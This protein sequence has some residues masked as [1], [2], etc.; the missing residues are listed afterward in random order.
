[1]CLLLSFRCFLFRFS[2]FCLLV[3]WRPVRRKECVL[4]SGV[5][6]LEL[7]LFSAG[8]RV[9]ASLASER[10][11]STAFMLRLLSHRVRNRSS[12]AVRPLVRPI[13]D[14]LSFRRLTTT[15]AGIV[16]DDGTPSGEDD[17]VEVSGHVVA[18]DN[19]SRLVMIQ[20]D[21]TKKSTRQFRPGSL[22][23]MGSGAVGCLAFELAGFNFA[24]LLPEAAVHGELLDD[25]SC[26]KG[27]EVHIS[28][29]Q[30]HFHF[31]RSA[32]AG[33]SVLDCFGQTLL[34]STP[35]DAE[36]A[37]P[38]N[39]EAESEIVQLAFNP[40]PG[41][42][43]RQVIRDNIHTG[44][45]ALDALTPFGR[46][47]SMLVHGEAGTGKSSIAMDVILAQHEFGAGRVKCVYAA[48][49]ADDSKM[50][51]IVSNMLAP[52]GDVA[53]VIASSSDDGD[54]GALFAALSACALGEHHRD[55]GDH[56]MVILD[57][58]SGLQRLWDKGWQMAH[59]HLGRETTPPVEIGQLRSWYMP[60]LQR[61][62]KLNDTK[63]GGGSMSIIAM[64]DT[65]P[66]PADHPEVM[67]EASLLAVDTGSA[68]ARP[69]TK[70][71]IED[72]DLSPL[73]LS[74]LNTLRER[75]VEV[76]L[77]MLRQL[78]IRSQ[79]LRGQRALAAAAK[80]AHPYYNAYQVSDCVIVCPFPEYCALVVAGR[81][82]PNNLSTSPRLENFF[83][84]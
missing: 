12:R 59:A 45:T 29:K 7:V 49:H 47:Q 39:A 81:K 54:E 9:S 4:V 79:K 30:L 40:A 52:V 13:R 21:F 32:A 77:R 65:P 28:S 31:D 19:A 76:D 58:V 34:S 73:D 3:F 56:A 11:C 78:G 60:L 25:P 20:P 62:A 16:E 50:S 61:A 6:G 2:F 67:P 70:Q 72:L 46:G 8:R 55:R 64:V 51:S 35:S 24:I 23:Q 48:T 33:G 80:A 43:D 38:T 5:I 22:V 68:D 10:V 71:D 75:G 44:V 42:F 63:K 17:A 83:I 74:R 14:A 36:T 1:M 84:S 37:S 15:S 18:A 57:E 66:S 41:Q 26:I 82:P 27:T 69:L 53:T